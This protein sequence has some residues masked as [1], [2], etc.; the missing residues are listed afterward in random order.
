MRPTKL[1]IAALVVAA[2]PCF[3]G[4]SDLPSSGPIAREVASQEGQNSALGG[5]IVV[6]I[7]ERIASITS[8]QPRDSFARVFHNTG[9]APDLRVGVGDSV[10]VT[11]YEAAAGGL[12]SAGVNDKSATA[13][14][15]TAIIP[16]QVVARD[17][18]IKVPYAGRLRVAGMR[19]SSVEEAVVKAL[20]GKAIEPQ[21]V[22]TITKNYSNT[23]TVGGEVVAGNRV[24]L[25]PR[26]DRILDVIASAGGIKVGA[27]EA[28]IRLTRRNNT[29][30]VGYNAI[31]A[32]PAENIYVLPDDVITVVRDPQ[33]FTTFGATG[34]SEKVPFDTAGITLEEAL[35]KGGGLLDNRADPGG[36][37]LFRFEPS[38]LVAQMVP[39]RPLPSEGNL[40]PIVYRLNLHEAN[41][42]FLARSFPV[43]DKDILYIANSASDPVQKFLGLVGTVTSPVISGAILYGTY[44]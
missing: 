39:G 36:I 2:L 5:Y 21:A 33:T 29:V 38:A 9:P 32:S 11:I 42:F 30:S 23:A 18:T 40:V 35:A 27:H 31:L 14:S 15:R 17:G 4:C 24:S 13:G 19:P 10:V 26:G 41:S 8:S 25:N 28:F 44:K 22:V 6:D 7:D 16:E 43:K 1:A 37:F 20:E 12:F 3:T 34:R